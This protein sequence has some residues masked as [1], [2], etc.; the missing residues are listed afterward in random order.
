MA[1]EMP[2]PTTPGSDSYRTVARYAEHEIKVE[3]SR[4]VGRV[5][6]VSS[7]AETGSFLADIQRT[8]HD[9]THHCFAYRL[10]CGAQMSVRFSDAGEPPGTAGRPLLAALE[11]R[12]LTNTIVVVTRYFGGVKLGTG[13]LA[14]A[15]GRCAAETLDRA[16][17][18]E[19]FLTR[20]FAVTFPY[21]LQHAVLQ[22]LRQ[23]QGK[24]LA[25]DFRDE[26]T[27]LVAVRQGLAEQFLKRLMDATS[28]KAVVRPA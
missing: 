9:A 22:V 10:G 12:Q 18:V 11:A 3:G 7:Q 23:V 26:A 17:V 20:S 27:L 8:F 25:C 21:H 2:Q 13:G 5:R 6:A 24:V 1:M 15:Y 4:F 14:R 28:G 19:R 16:G